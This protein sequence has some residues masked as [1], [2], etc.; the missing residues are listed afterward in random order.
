MVNLS[1]PGGEVAVLFEVLREGRPVSAAS[2]LSET[3]DEVAYLRALRSTSG[4]KAVTGRVAYGVLRVCSVEQR[5]ARRQLVNIRRVHP[6]VPVAA[7]LRPCIVR[8]DEQNV[9]AAP[10][11]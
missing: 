10:F 2:I 4:H 8:Y 3:R 6:T 5:A 7:K 9:R 1:G 11:A